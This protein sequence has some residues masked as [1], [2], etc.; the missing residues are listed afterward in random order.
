MIDIITPQN[1]SEF[2]FE[3]DEMHRMRYDVAVKQ[4]GWNIPGLTDNF[5]KDQ[6]DKEDTVYILGYDASGNVKAC[7][8]L[9]RTDRP[10]LLSEIFPDQCE[11]RGVPSSPDILEF[12]RFVIDERGLTNL[13]K[14]QLSLKISLAV[15]EYCFD[16]QATHITFLAYKATYT[17]GVVLW[18]TRPLGVPKYYEEDDAT[19]IAGIGEI[20]EDAIKRISRFAR[21]N[22]RVGRY[23]R[24]NKSRV[25]AA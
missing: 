3:I 25:I 8:R 9:N 6:F 17:K 16:N 21:V 24:M 19:Y 23:R 12:S 4:W 22:G 5:D 14:L 7:G 13:Q 1:K 15:T 10:H 20:S 2:Q 11:F 18:K